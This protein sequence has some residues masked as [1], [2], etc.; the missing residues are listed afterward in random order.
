MSRPASGRVAVSGIL[1][2]DGENTVVGI[3]SAHPGTRQR[4]SRAHEL[5]HL[6]KRFWPSIKVTVLG[7]VAEDLRNIKLYIKK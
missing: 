6:M 7:A 1:Y 4:F 3:N 5:G 2:R